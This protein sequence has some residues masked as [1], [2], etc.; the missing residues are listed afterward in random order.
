MTRREV[1]EMLGLG[2]VALAGGAADQLL[3]LER[4]FV[5]LKDR[6]EHSAASLPTMTYFKIEDTGPGVGPVPNVWYKVGMAGDDAIVTRA[7]VDDREW[8]LAS[9]E[10][11]DLRP[12]VMTPIGD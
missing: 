3:T 11:G 12:Y 6:G 2:A 9:D 8:W 7:F 10:P 4:K 1:L 5:L